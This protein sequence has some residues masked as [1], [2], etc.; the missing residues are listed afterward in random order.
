MK[1]KQ[2]NLEGC[3][4][5]TPNVFE[6]K[7]GVFYETFNSETFQKLVGVDTVFVQDNQSTSKKGVLRGLHFQDGEYS[8]AKLVSVSYGSVLDVCVDIR[9]GSSTFGQHFSVILNSENRNQVYIPRGFAHGFLTLSDTVIF[10]YKC[11][12]YYNKA[13]EKGIIYNDST[14]N[15]DW[16][17]YQEDLILSD[18]DKKLPTLK[19]FLNEKKG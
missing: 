4:L 18:K 13:S 15:I 17:I 5:I 11:D 19:T 3:Y 12:N 1:I 10:N 14:L 7:R 2:T 16:G 6:D 8:Q 9:K